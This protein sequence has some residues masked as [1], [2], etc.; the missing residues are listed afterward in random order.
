MDH[1][2]RFRRYFSLILLLIERPHSGDSNK[3]IFDEKTYRYPKKK[4]FGVMF[5]RPV[6]LQ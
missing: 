3:P 6:R 1:N 4:S 5:Q 2:F